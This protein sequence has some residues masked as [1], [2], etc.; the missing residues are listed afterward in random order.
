[1]TLTN[2]LLKLKVNRVTPGRYVLETVGQWPRRLMRFFPALFHFFVGWGQQRPRLLNRITLLAPV[3]ASFS[4]FS[5]ATL[6]ASFLGSFLALHF[7][8]DLNVEVIRLPLL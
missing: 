7:P 8:E 2:Q 1:M 3:S 6:K 5:L 4:L